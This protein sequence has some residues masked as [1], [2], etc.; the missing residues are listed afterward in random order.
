MCFTSVD[1]LELMKTIFNAY[2][3]VIDILNSVVYM[4]AIVM[5]C[6]VLDAGDAWPLGETQGESPRYTFITE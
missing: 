5:L 1:V 2:L 4:S 3:K 6:L